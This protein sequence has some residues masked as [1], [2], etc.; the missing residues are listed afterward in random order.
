MISATGR[1]SSPTTSTRKKR[2]KGS[3]TALSALVE[4]LEQRPR[5]AFTASRP[6]RGTGSVR[7]YRAA[8]WC[9]SGASVSAAAGGGR[10]QDADTR[11]AVRHAASRPRGQRREG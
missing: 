4:C 7:V 2:E 6:V 10:L 3:C 11:P 1:C 9:K 5:L 8:L